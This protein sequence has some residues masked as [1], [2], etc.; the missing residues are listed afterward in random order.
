MIESRELENVRR[1][2]NGL[3][4]NLRAGA[5]CRRPPR[6][7]D[8][9]GLLSRALLQR[10]RAAAEIHMQIPVVEIPPDFFEMP[11][12]PRKGERIKVRSIEQRHK[13][14]EYEAASVSDFRD[15]FGKQPIQLFLAVVLHIEAEAVTLLL[16]V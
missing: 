1:R 3:G 5:G 6:Q 16:H 10:R 13:A 15:G 9:Q 11:A 14:F 8:L 2:F 12:I 7:T 4:K